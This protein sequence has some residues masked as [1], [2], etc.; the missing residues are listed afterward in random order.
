[1]GLLIINCE[2]NMNLIELGL[3][4]TTSQ[5]Y[6]FKKKKRELINGR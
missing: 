4:I 1:M 3:Q 5:T 6:K 2:L